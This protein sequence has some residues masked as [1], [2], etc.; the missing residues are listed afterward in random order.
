MIIRKKPPR[1]LGLNEP[2][3][4]GSHKRPVTRREFIAAGFLTGPAVV[5]APTLLGMLA[6]PGTARAALST[7]LNNM[8]A[9]PCNIQ[10]GAGK[11]PFICFDL[12]GGASMV[13]SEV[14]IG[15]PGGQLDFL[16]TAGYARLGLP[17]D[18][19]PN[20]P[21][22]GSPTNDFIDTSLGLAWHSDGAMLRGIREKASPAA[23]ALTNGCVIAARSENDTANNPHNPMYGIYRAGADGELLTLIGSRNTE[24]GGNSIAPAS[25]VDPAV[26]PTKVDRASDVTGLVDTGDLASMFANPDDAILVLESMA[27]LSHS[28]VEKIK[29][30]AFT[31]DAA[32]REALANLLKC[33]YVKSADLADRFRTPGDLDPDKDPDIV[34]PTGIFS[35]AEYNSDA[36]FRKTAAVMKMVIEGYAG[37]GTITMGGYDYHGQGRATGEIRNLRAGR[38][39]GACLEYAFRKGKPLMLYVFSDGSLSAD[40]QVDNSPDG[41]GKFMWASDNQSTA[42]SFFLVFN[43]AGRPEIRDGFGG[44]PAERKQQI[45]YFQRDGSVAN[46]SSP[47]ANAVNL[48]VETVILNY[49]ALHGEEGLFAAPGYFPNH[50]LGSSQQRDALTVFAPIV[51]GKIGG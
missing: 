3:R 44:V 40:G 8:K 1:Q 13:G 7:D 12:A 41:R 15:G 16:S 46:N 48:L 37:A 18:M 36:E 17:G 39:I 11:I 33:S 45:G 10:P 30:A 19:V 32:R 26:R 34:G 20:A 24:S 6:R 29:N 21:N 50:G 51:N 47:A 49:M 22:P 5:A 38:C 35:Q 31:S 28:K 27:R 23:Q 14:L 9:V 25:M 43:P 4:H 2:I 42:A